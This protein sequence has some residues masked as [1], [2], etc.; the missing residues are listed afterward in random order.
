MHEADFVASSNRSHV[1]RSVKCKNTKPEMI[2]RRNLHKHGFRFRLHDR[3]L[4]GSPDLVLRKYSAVIFVHGCFWHRHEGCKLASSPKTRVAFWQSKFEK[5]IK[6]DRETTQKLIQLDFRVAFVWEC[7]LKKNFR[8]ETLSNLI[9]W[10]PSSVSRF[11]SG[12]FLT[13]HDA[14]VAQA[15]NV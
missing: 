4:P 6:R 7:G 13:R 5:N 12:I 15:L 10:V 14:T 1:M 8:D 3:T 2:V 11:D 9:E